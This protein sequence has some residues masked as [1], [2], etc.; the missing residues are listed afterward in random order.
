MGTNGGR[1]SRVALPVPGHAGARPGAAQTLR[2][3]RQEGAHARAGAREDG[4]DGRVRA[5]LDR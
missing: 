5:G 3:R 1:F 4:A 2:A